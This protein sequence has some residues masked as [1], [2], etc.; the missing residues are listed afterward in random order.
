M[1]TGIIQTV[2]EV[3]LRDATRLEISVA[4]APKDWEPFKLGESIAVNGVC[5]TL[6]AENPNLCFEISEE[7][8][9]RTALGALTAGSRVNLERAMRASD[10]FGGHIVQGHVDGVS[11]VISLESR[12]EFSVLTV[13]VPEGGEKYLIDKGSIAL[14]GTSLTVVNPRGREF[15]V[16][17]VPHTLANTIISDYQPGTKLN[18]E[19]DVLVKHLEKLTQAR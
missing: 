18:T 15:E 6:I 3:A 13:R 7:T 1:F 8:W 11:E 14:D 10:R 12:G 4:S 9:K 17:L 16:W 2:G 5:L 19:F